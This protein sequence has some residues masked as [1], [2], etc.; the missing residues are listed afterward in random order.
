MP[1][2]VVL[3]VDL[4]VVQAVAH[5][6]HLETNRQKPQLMHQVKVMMVVI[7]PDLV[8]MVV[9]AEAALEL[10]VDLIVMVVLVVLA[11]KFPQHSKIQNLLLV[12]SQIQHH[13]KEVVV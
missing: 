12:T 5:L 1:T 7:A 2:L 6:E 13:I 3:V 10:L 8:H 11:L 4:V 9:A